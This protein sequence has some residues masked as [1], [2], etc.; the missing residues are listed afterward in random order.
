MALGPIEQQL[1]ERFCRYVA[2]SS[3]SNARSTQLPS[4]DGQHHLAALLAEELQ[5]LGLNVV[6]DDNAIVTAFK[7]GTLKAAPAVGFIAHLD[8]VD[9]GLSPDIRPQILQFTGDDL[10]LNKQQGIWLCVDEHPEIMPYLGQEI[11]FSDG[12]SVLGADNKAAI[13]IIMTA[14]ANLTADTSHGDLHIA[15][16]PDEEI[17]LRGAKTLDLSRFPVEFAY[18]IDCCEA[19]E[20]VYQTFN[21]ASAH[22]EITGV[23]AHPMSAKGVL[24]NPLLVATDFIAYFDRQQTPECTESREGYFWF[25]EIEADQNRA[26]LRMVIRDFDLDTF[27]A[28]K[29]QIISAVEQIKK[30]HPK[31]EISCSISDT[32]ANIANAIKNDRRAIDLAFKAMSSLGITPKV[33]DMRGG[34]DGSELSRRGVLTPNYFTGAHNFHSRFEFLPITSF[35]LSYQV[36]RQLIHLAANPADSES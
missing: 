10:C 7:P 5:Q 17:G 32:Y 30:Q 22:I 15:F 23:T 33:L 28:R 6:V 34:T 16:V 35:E 1:V 20:L 36:T 8:T 11:L 21:A 24:V 19:G 9:V 4:S 3:Q 31:A 26:S 13:A 2:I 12:T 18:T 29:S 25:Q 14:M 27:N